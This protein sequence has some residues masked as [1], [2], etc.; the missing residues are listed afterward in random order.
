MFSNYLNSVVE[1][2]TNKDY[3]VAINLEFDDLVNNKIWYLISLAKD[4]NVI[5]CNWIYKTKLKQDGSLDRCKARLVVKGFKQSHDINYNDSFN[6]VAKMSTI[7]IVLS[8]VVSSGWSLHQIDLQ[9]ALLHVHLEE[10]I[11][12]MQPSKYEDVFKHGYVCKLDKSIY[13]LK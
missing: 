9:N 5:G 12:N 8:V 6:L 4:H 11:Y 7:H 1:A 10:D 3:D 2:S 13:G